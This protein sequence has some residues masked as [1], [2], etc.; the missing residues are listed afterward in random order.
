MKDIEIRDHIGIYNDVYSDTQIKKWISY[1]DHCSEVGLT[2][3]RHNDLVRDE[4]L[5]VL[6]S[7]YHN[8]VDLRYIIE[9]F[10]QPFF[11]GPYTHYTN[12]YAVLKTIQCHRILDVKVQKTVPGQGYHAWHCESTM[13]ENRFRLC[14]FMLY[15]ND[16][17][18]GG[19]TEFIHQKTRFKPVKN[20]LLIWPAGYTHTHRGNP[21][22]SGAKYI[23]TGWVETS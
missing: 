21:P 17:E 3:K 1:F 15:L 20:Q 5:D 14:A 2:Y 22:I 23:L 13:H 10:H 18:E 12:E 8:E 9:D 7:F 16:V 11:D 6:H 4:G 19:E